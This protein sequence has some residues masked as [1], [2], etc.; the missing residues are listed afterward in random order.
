MS[1][2]CAFGSGRLPV[3]IVG[4]GEA[5]AIP[6]VLRCAD[7]TGLFDRMYS[8]M[9]NFDEPPFNMDFASAL[10]DVAANHLGEIEYGKTY[11]A[12]ARLI[13]LQNQFRKDTTPE[14]MA[15]ELNFSG[16]VSKKEAL[17]IIK[18]F[19]G[20][21]TENVWNTSTKERGDYIK[22][23]LELIKAKRTHEAFCYTLETLKN[24]P[25]VKEL[26]SSKNEKARF[27]KSSWES[28]RYFEFDGLCSVL[29]NC[30][31]EKV[32]SV[33]TAKIVQKEI[34]EA[35]KT[36]K[37]KGIPNYLFEPFDV[38]ARF[39]WLKE[40]A[41]FWKNEIKKIE[42]KLYDLENGTSKTKK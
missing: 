18:F 12:L 16:H 23:C 30:F 42:V 4:C 14:S 10:A 20:R 2:N 25:E 9:P 32:I 41:N 39:K 7:G 5:R 38:E 6:E 24:L 36:Q 19:N 22:T 33:N 27:F 28:Y 21:N 40:K 29:K 17:R 35:L 3:G 15:F 8:Q 11:K 13:P 1:D 26:K 37:A 31:E 34:F